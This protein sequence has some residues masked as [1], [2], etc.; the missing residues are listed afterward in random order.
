MM[1]WL[2]ASLVM[3]MLLVSAMAAA[4]ETGADAL[5][6]KMVGAVDRLNY[7]GVFVFARDGHMETMH[8]LHSRNE[9]G[10]RERLTALTG[11]PR[12]VIKDDQSITCIRADGGSVCMEPRKTLLG[13]PGMSP[14]QD[15][16]NGLRDNYR[17]GVGGS[18][19]I[20]GL[21][22]REVT[23]LPRDALRY[24]HLL[25]IHEDSGMLL[26]AQL[27]GQEGV[28]LEQFMFTHIEFPETLDE[29]RF[30]PA[31]QGEGFSVQRMEEARAERE[32][33]EP[34]PHW[35]LRNLPEGFRVTKVRKRT[36]EANP[37]P[38]QH[39]LLSDG[40]ATVS[41]FIAQA[42]RPDDLLMGV[43]RSGALHAAARPVGDYQITVL[44][45]VPAAT[46]RLIAESVV[47]EESP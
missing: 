5:I 28:V 34:D 14:L 46:V 21:S 9:Q 15:G 40:M 4:S 43:T 33:M 44:G 3:A 6:G 22:C 17:L 20:A 13:M 19:R 8:I 26:K 38:V 30:E 45:E 31:I 24:G 41:V 23:I 32:F 37:H 12:E 1:R 29:E 10:S 18:Q 25:C 2:P 11:E 47:H 39:M 36:M 35:H 16:T 7:E 42:E 27:Q